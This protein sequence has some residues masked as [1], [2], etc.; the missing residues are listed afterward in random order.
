MVNIGS[1]VRVIKRDPVQHQYYLKEGTV[2]AIE[3][4]GVR[5]EFEDI[6]CFSEDELE[7][8]NV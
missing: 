6:C 4:W 7:V 2:I 8:L 3:D 5:V 1:I